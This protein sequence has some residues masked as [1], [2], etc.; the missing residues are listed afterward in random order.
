MKS[1]LSNVY[2]F[3]TF[4]FFAFLQVWF[5][6]FIFSHVFK[7]VFLKTE[8]GKETMYGAF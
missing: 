5:L 4:S 6:A 7:T 8:I 3:D 1:S 2:H